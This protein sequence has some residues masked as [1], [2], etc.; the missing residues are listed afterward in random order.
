[1]SEK[2]RL[3]GFAAVR[4]RMEKW[5]R[6]Q[7][8]RV[9]KWQDEWFLRGNTA[10]KMKGGWGKVKHAMA[11]WEERHKLDVKRKEV[12]REEMRLKLL[13]EDVGRKTVSEESRRVDW[14][15]IKLDNPFY[16]RP[17]SLKEQALAQ[18]VQ[19]SVHVQEK[20]KAVKCGVQLRHTGNRD[21]EEEEGKKSVFDAQTLGEL[22]RGLKNDE[23]LMWEVEE[24]L[25][26]NVTF[27]AVTEGTCYTDCEDERE[28]YW[29]NLV[30]EHFFCYQW[31]HGRWSSRIYRLTEQFVY[32]KAMV[33]NNEQEWDEWE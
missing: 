32:D 29:T 24:A 7:I 2:Q 21:N 26:R 22:K 11:Q 16:H 12:E 8:L 9:D 17:P 13:T 19:Q 28:K 6:D 5:E 18:V 23:D 20:R 1:M 30:M 3:R 10:L 14:G 33:V 31:L 27:L 25:A 4:N 15:I